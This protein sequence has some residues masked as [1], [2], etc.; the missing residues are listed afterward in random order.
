MAL[1]GYRRPVFLVVCALANLASNLALNLTLA[2][3]P[4]HW[5]V[6]LLPMLE[7]A[8][9]VAEW[10]VLRL[11][12]AGPNPPPLRSRISVRLAIATVLAN[13]LSFTIGVI[14]F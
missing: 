9:V 4:D 10:A 3:A 7:L 1:V 8:V 5:R 13:V 11:V 14:L 2:L 12:V 6:G